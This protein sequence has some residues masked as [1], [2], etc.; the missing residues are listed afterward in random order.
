M[1][2]QFIC[3]KTSGLPSDMCATDAATHSYSEDASTV[4]L[5]I[6]PT[7]ASLLIK[8]LV[9]GPSSS[10]EVISVLSGNLTQIYRS[11]NR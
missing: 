11:L 5:N 10:G 4:D 3:S 1:L 7:S 9:T 8:I 2:L 6:G